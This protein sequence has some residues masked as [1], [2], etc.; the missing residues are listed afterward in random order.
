MDWKFL[1]LLI[2]FN[3]YK[4]KAFEVHNEFT[5]HSDNKNYL[6]LIY[7]KEN[8]QITIKEIEVISTSYY[9]IELSLEL[10][11]KQNKVF[12]Q[13]DTLKEAYECIKK[14]FEK[15]KIKIY[16]TYNNISL[17]L[18]MNS[19]SCDNEEVIFKLEEKKMSKDEINEMVLI[20]NNI[21]IKKIKALE[22][23][24]MKLKNM[25]NEYELRLNESD[26]KIAYID[27]KILSN[28]CELTSII[29]EFKKTY[30]NINSRTYK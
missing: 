8:I 28:K 10:L 13:Y 12:K 29:N 15:E 7:L 4:S 16:N 19:A 14:L 9:Y 6:A 21:L 2:I 24:N 3:L 23:E 30:K 11:Y 17:L 5:I 26:L 20:D 22:E 27:S 1:F 18:L 25:L